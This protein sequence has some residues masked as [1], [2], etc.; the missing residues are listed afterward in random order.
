[1]LIRFRPGQSS[2]EWVILLHDHKS[3]RIVEKIFVKL[4][5]GT[6][7]DSRVISETYGGVREAYCG[8][9][10]MLVYLGAA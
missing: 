1:M 6:A 7:A 4:I 9:L 5:I 10:K 3:S 2:H 8:S